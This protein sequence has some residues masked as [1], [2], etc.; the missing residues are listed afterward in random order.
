MSNSTL[1]ALFKYAT[2]AA[3]VLIAGPIIM[4][5]ARPLATES[6]LTEATL[7]TA[8]S[9]TQ[10]IIV[11]VAAIIL[12]TAISIVGGFLSTRRV[13]MAAIGLALAW[14]AQT[15]GDVE[16]IIR[17]A[18]TP[19]AISNVFT[20]FAIEG[21]LLALPL[22]IIMH[23]AT[24]LGDINAPEELKA[25][26]DPA[27]LISKDSA[28]AIVVALAV[29]AVIIYFG[30]PT[31][32]N[33]QALGIS[34]LAGAAGALAAH[35]AAPKASIATAYI[36]VLLVSVV[37]PLAAVFALAPADPLDALY[38]GQLMPVLLVHPWHVAAG[39]AIGVP[40]GDAWARSLIEKHAPQ[41]ATA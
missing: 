19:S 8:N 41:P 29:G 3:A 39:A 30:M 14:P 2:Y 38:S 24:K 22:L 17:D 20:S 16:S 6:G 15:L 35:A 34:A 26:P 27:P 32:Y 1:Q 9:L 25:F 40:V 5:L 10:A 37:A 4:M 11:Y 12:V 13:A 23:I 36:G 31:A 28:L 18:H 33:G 7:L 21:L